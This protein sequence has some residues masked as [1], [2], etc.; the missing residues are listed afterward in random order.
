[1]RAAALPS[2]RRCRCS[3]CYYWPATSYTTMSTTRNR[4]T[5]SA[6]NAGVT[7][8]Q[9]SRYDASTT[10]DPDPFYRTSTSPDVHRCHGRCWMIQHADLV[11]RR[12]VRSTMKTRG[13]VC[14]VSPYP[15]AE[16]RTHTADIDTV[17][18]LCVFS[19]ESLGGPT[20]K[21]PDNNTHNCSAKPKVMA[22]WVGRDSGP[23]FAFCR[24]KFTTLSMQVQSMHLLHAKFHL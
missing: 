19:G 24:P 2:P 23:F 4:H 12:R 13:S 20:V 3:Q 21:I 6:T 11:V 9:T 8:T 14:A 10:A 7:R 1:M 15:D 17:S 16:R 22:A 5:S 18:L